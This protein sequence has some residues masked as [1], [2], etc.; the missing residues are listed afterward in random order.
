MPL[1]K[2]F[3]AANLSAVF[4]AASLW[5]LPGFAIA[6]DGPAPG[7]PASPQGAPAAPGQSGDGPAVVPD[8]AGGNEDSDSSA[9]HSGSGCPYQNYEP[10]LIS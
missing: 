4:F 2:S 7:A 10:D 3:T 1:A 6:A 9:G 5:V 8:G